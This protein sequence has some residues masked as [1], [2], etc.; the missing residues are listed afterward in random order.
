MYIMKKT[1]EINMVRAFLNFIEI[2]DKYTKGHCQRVAKYSM[3]IGEEMK[4][5]END[6]RQLKYAALLHDIGKIGIPRD[7]LKK[8]GKLHEKEYE[9]IKK[10]SEIGYEIICKIDFLRTSSEILLQHHERIDGRGYPSCLNG[11]SISILAKIISVADSYDAMTSKRIYKDNVLSK[12]AAT[13]EL[14]IN[15]GTQFDPKIVDIFSNII[16]SN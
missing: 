7:I 11:N 14:R 6:L 13:E 8:K 16:K 9:I 2:K 5:G 4:L 12:K 1:T 3:L 15:S 10:H